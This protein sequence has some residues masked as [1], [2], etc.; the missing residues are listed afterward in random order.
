MP[1]DLDATWTVCREDLSKQKKPCLSGVLIGAAH[2]R[3]SGLDQ[4]VW[5]C[6]D[7]PTHFGLRLKQ[8]CLLNFCY[9]KGTICIICVSQSHTRPS[10]F[11]KTLHGTF[12]VVTTDCDVANRLQQ[13][14]LHVSGNCFPKAGRQVTPP[15][16][17]QSP[18]RCCRSCLMPWWELF[19][20]CR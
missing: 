12:E 9:L 14:S 7:K 5:H 13:P 11:I 16:V 4:P 6:K 19:R 15:S 8:S 3:R 20:P 10:R 2:E 18:C 17:H 1:G